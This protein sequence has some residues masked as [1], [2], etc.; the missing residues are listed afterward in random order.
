RETSQRSFTAGWRGTVNDNAIIQPIGARGQSGAGNTEPPR[1]AGRV[2]KAGGGIAE[3]IRQLAELHSAAYGED[4]AIAGDTGRAAISEAAVREERI[5][6]QRL[7]L[8]DCLEVM[9]TL[10]PV[11]HVISDPPYGVADTHAKRLSKITLRDGTPA[12]QALGFDGISGEQLVELAGKWC[13]LAERWVVF[14]CEW[15]DA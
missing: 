9:P 4:Q 5:G 11:D 10:G 14:T 6:N 8:G 1:P 7:I 3:A 2:A 15:K 12:G 13:S